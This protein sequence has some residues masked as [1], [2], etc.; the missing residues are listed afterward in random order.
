M[1]RLRKNEPLEVVYLLERK[2]ALELFQATKTK[3]RTQAQHY[4]CE[5]LNP[6]LW[7]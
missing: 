7:D 5:G 6:Q 2:T 3:R 1:L 4:T